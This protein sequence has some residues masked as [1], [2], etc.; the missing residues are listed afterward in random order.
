MIRGIWSL[1]FEAGI[2]EWI[3][4]ENVSNPA[5]SSFRIETF[6]RASAALME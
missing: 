5:L 4:S 3:L 2:S 6:E 1:C